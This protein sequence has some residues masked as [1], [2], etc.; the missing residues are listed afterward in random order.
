M[1][2]LR[3]AVVLG[4]S[5]PLVVFGCGSDDGTTQPPA[6]GGEG[7]ESPGGVVGG[8]TST[9]GLPSVDG[10]APVGGAPVEPLAG[11][12][13]GGTSAE[14][15]G[16]GGL[17]GAAGAGGE[18][19]A[20]QPVCGDAVVNGGLLCFEGPQSFGLSEG[21]PADIAIGNWD[22]KEGL[23]LVVAGSGLV[24]FSNSGGTF[25]AETYLGNA[26]TVLG[27]GQISAEGDLD[28]LLGL[29]DPRTTTILL[30]KGDGTVQKGVDAATNSEGQLYNY[31]VAD[32]A[33]TGPGADFV[34]TH[35]WSVNL[36]VSSGTGVDDFQ[37]SQDEFYGRAE[38]GVLAKLGSSQW[39]VYSSPGESPSPGAIKR[40]SFS[41]TDGAVSI[42]DDE[43]STPVGGSPAQLDVGDFNEDG[44]DDVVATLSDS[45][46][47]SVSFA[48]GV[49]TG[50]FAVVE[51][52]NR[53]L[54]LNIAA[55]DGAKT[56]RDVKVGDFNGDGHADIAVS[57]KAL[58]AVATFVGDGE[59]G[60]SEPTLLSTGSGS[61]PGRLAVGD[62]ND[63][64]VDDLVAVGE[65]NSSLIPLLSDP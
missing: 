52:S 31:F 55:S 35:H 1:K 19:S 32:V 38:D 34:V 62:I 20:P 36:V 15:G 37:T 60:F 10:G 29:D 4:V 58:N 42:S 51:G 16:A 22:D 5:T 49:G 39:I 3:A 43:L 7:G 6:A 54:T 25:Q 40:R 45:G 61:G 59:G 64:G 8:D 53:F 23:D 65:S 30:G 28:L 27:A 56:Q 14:D 17:S 57:V 2:V 21:K 18:P 46:S 33:G 24:Y 63:D 12:G 41:V 47:V 44:F 48:D 9:G 50:D 11:Q 13:G 26:G